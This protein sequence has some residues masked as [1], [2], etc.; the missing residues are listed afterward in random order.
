MGWEE[1]KRV[2]INNLLLNSDNP[3]IINYQ[4]YKYPVQ[5]PVDLQV[6]DVIGNQKLRLK[7]YAWPAHHKMDSKE[8]PQ[9][10]GKGC[11]GVVF[12]SHGWS[13]YAGR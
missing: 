9:F 7:C 4:L 5:D 13:D 11:K 2:L 10:G 8:K 1:D 6:N 3:R 12:Y